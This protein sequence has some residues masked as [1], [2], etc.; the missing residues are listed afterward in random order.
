MEFDCVTLRERP[1]LETDIG[2]LHHQFP[3]FILGGDRTSRKH[4][5]N[6]YRY[7]PEFQFTLCDSNGSVAACGHAIPLQWDGDVEHL[8]SGYDGVLEDGFESL[9]QRRTPNTL[10]ALAAVTSPKYK[11]VGLSYQIINTMKYLAKMYDLQT[12]I[13]PVR[14]TWKGKYPLTPMEKYVRWI[15]NDGSSFDPW[16]RVH[17]RLGG[18]YLCVAQYSMTVTGSIREWEDWTNM[19]FP[20][21]GQYVVPQAFNPVEI[22][23]QNDNGLYI[24]PNVWINHKVQ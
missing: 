10:C 6:L 19:S 21:T 1:E 18:S 14:P 13:A 7:Y 8:P 24:E 3:Q 12:L 5:R 15:R 11:S 9:N 4:W 23:L 16:I 2:H 17:F 22:D 20:E